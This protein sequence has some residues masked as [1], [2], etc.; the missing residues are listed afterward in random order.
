MGESRASL[1]ESIP[2]GMEDLRCTSGVQFTEDA[3]VRLT[4]AAQSSIDLTALYWALPPP[5][6]ASTPI[7]H[8]WFRMLRAVF[9]RDWASSCAWRL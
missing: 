7:T 9:D 8:R 3:L 1:V 5:E 6:A 2:V 4:E